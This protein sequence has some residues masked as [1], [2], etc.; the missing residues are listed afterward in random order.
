MKSLLVKLGVILIGLAIF[1]Y[2]EAWGFD[3]KYLGENYSYYFFY[4]TE[5]IT[6]LSKEIVRTWGKMTFKELGR[7]Y[8]VEKLGSRFENL[9]LALGLWELNCADKTMRSLT[10]TYYSKDGK[11]IDSDTAVTKWQFITP[12]TFIEA[13]YKAVCK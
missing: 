2:S 4:D 11:V 10:V 5:N 8:T 3:W 12:G 7:I 1:G 9:E 13:L 6:H